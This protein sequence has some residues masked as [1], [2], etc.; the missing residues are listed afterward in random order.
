MVAAPDFPWGAGPEDM[1][2]TLDDLQQWGTLGYGEAWAD[3]F[4]QGGR[5]RPS[6]EAARWWARLSRNACTPD[7][8]IGAYAVVV[9]SLAISSTFAQLAV[10]A[11]VASL[12]MYLLCCA[13]SWQLQ[14]RDVQAGGVPF[15]T[16]GGP[17]VPTLAVAA[18]VWMLAH[19]TWHELAV[20]ALVLAIASL[21]YVIRSTR[22]T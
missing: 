4:E 18:I 10:L 13:G 20:E 17:A 15:R 3:T 19:A 1:A 6:E 11:N 9:A 7:V 2:G 22:G 5:Y 12:S 16:P 14:R 21:L 8:A